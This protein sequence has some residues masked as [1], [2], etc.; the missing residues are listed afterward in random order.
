MVTSYPV[1]PVAQI[2]RRSAVDLLSLKAAVDL[3][4]DVLKH[5]RSLKSAV[6]RH[7]RYS[8]QIICGGNNSRSTADLLR[9]QLTAVAGC[10]AVKD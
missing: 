5:L 10:T 3:L 1:V 9:S 6:V 2:D 8:P 7:R 4:S